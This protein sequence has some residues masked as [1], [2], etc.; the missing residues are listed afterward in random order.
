M[1]RFPRGREKDLAVVSSRAWVELSQGFV[2]L[3]HVGIRNAT[4]QDYNASQLMQ[5]QM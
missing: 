5:I 1:C 2:D 3:Y 4:L